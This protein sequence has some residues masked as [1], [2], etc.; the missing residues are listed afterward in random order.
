MLG[1]NDG[2]N[3]EGDGVHGGV[4]GHVIIEVGIEGEVTN[5]EAGVGDNVLSIALGE[6]ADSEEAIRDPADTYL[7]A[8]NS[9]LGEHDQGVLTLRQTFGDF[10]DD[11]LV[12]GLGVSKHDFSGGVGDV[13]TL[14]PGGLAEDTGEDDGELVGLV[15]LESL[16]VEG[17]SLRRSHILNSDGVDDLNGAGLNA[18]VELDGAEGEGVEVESIIHNTSERG[19]DSI[20]DVVGLRLQ[21]GIEGDLE[22]VSHGSVQVVVD[23]LVVVVEVHLS[24]LETVE[25]EVVDVIGT[26]LRAVMDVDE[27]AGEILD[28]VAEL[29]EITVGNSDF[30]IEVA[31][32]RI[33]GIHTVCSL[34]LVVLDLLISVGFRDFSLSVNEV[35]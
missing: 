33:G 13:V 6:G 2:T 15:A 1:A 31:R 28:L 19:G 30:V 34:S 23:V 10:R 5:K 27:I 17:S 24:R 9:L 22:G 8:V 4:G 16:D 20:D 3:G 32:I 21:L 14:V 18:R 25:G 29:G 7:V 26:G 35:A 12:G 11:V